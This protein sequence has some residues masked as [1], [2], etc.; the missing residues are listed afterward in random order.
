MSVLVST[1]IANEV[2]DFNRPP[3]RTDGLHHH[4]AGAGDSADTGCGW[5]GCG[6]CYDY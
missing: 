3:C 6:I 1:E 2:Y 4:A 5:S